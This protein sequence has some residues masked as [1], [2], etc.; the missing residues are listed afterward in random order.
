M[1]NIRKILAG[2]LA[3]TIIGTSSSVF[4]W[5]YEVKP[6]DTYWKISQKYNISMDTLLKV[7]NA[8]ENTVLY[9]GDK[10]NIPESENFFYYEVKKGDTPY[11][12]S[13]KFD[14]NLDELLK[15]NGLSNSSLIY[16]GDRLRIPI[17]NTDTNMDRNN[18]NFE[19]KTTKT[20][21]TYIVQPGDDFWKISQ[22]FGI[23]M[24]ELMKVNNANDRT[25]LY[26]GDKLIVPVY[27][28]SV[29][30]TVGEKYGEYLDWWKGAQYLIPIGAK[31]KVID[32]YTGKSFMAKRTAGTN[33]ADVETLTAYDTKKFKEIWGGS[34]SW[35][36]RPV[37][38]EYKG[39]R[40]A[41]SASGMPHAGNDKAPGGVYTSWR[42]GGYG[43][44]VNLDY[45]KN[46]GMNGHFDIHFLNSTR[47]KDGKIDEKHQY[48]IKIAAGI[49]K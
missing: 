18:V 25:V 36:R 16:P 2:T 20:Y 8:N 29:M 34:F 37:I 5:T 1:K 6:G 22:K 41:A 7:N 33:H 24:Y 9:V 32:F 47:H 42:S 39:R 26:T 38:I 10:L 17:N 11:L 14:V 13:K 21:K 35:V 19:T 45:I 3:V 23:P 28:V 49:I 43:G 44:G 31:F 40:I 30:E 27:N 15:I 4:A 12:I 46:N 48:C